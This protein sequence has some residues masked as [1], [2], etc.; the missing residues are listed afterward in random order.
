MRQVT[1][2][3]TRQSTSLVELQAELDKRERDVD[4]LKEQLVQIDQE[5]VMS[6]NRIHQYEKE[7]EELLGQLRE[8]G[9]ELKAEERRIVELEQS[10]VNGIIAHLGNVIINVPR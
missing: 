5:N 2:E 7:R 10:E 8:K 3:V 6:K 9:A 4:E 1:D